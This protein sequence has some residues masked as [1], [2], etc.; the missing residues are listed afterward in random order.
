MIE[1]LLSFDKFIFLLINNSFSNG[2]LDIFFTTITE[3]KFWIIPAIIGIVLFVKVEKK[4]A[5]LIIGLSLLTVAISDPVSSQILKPFFSRYRPCHPNFFI[6]GGNFLC[7]MK[8]SY[9]F[10]SSHAMNIFAQAA[11][12]SFFYP[13]K[14]LI[15]Y[16]FAFTIGIS[17][18]YV[19]VHYPSDI[20]AGAFFG[21]VSAYV[22]ILSFS[23]IKNRHQKLKTAATSANS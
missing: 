9:S 23:F 20:L 19:G 10:P 4:K 22:V 11:L 17:R 13:K 15:F 8:K 6:E 18:I 7:G 5:L 14:A 21:I 12:F 3:A 16:I 1:Q 2:L